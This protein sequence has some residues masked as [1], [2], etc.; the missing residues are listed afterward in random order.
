VTVQRATAPAHEGHDAGGVEDTFVG[1]GLYDVLPVHAWGLVVLVVAPAAAALAWRWSDRRPGGRVP[2]SW[3]AAS[4]ERRVAVSALVLSAA[5]HAALVPSHGWSAWSVL[6]AVDALALGGAAWLLISG[7]RGAALVASAVLLGSLLGLAVSAA[8]GQTPDQVAMLTKLVEIAGLVALWAPLAARRGPRLLGVAG[9]TLVALVVAVPVWG[10][11]LT[12]EAGQDGRGH[13]GHGAHGDD[14]SSDPAAAPVAP[15]PQERAAAE[16][17]YAR[18][19]A[20]LV[21]YADPAVAAADGYAVSG[22]RGR[23]FHAAHETYAKDGRVLD[24]ERPEYLIYAESDRGPLLLGAMFE[25]ESISDV[26]PRVGGPLTP[27]HRHEQVCFSLLPPTVAGMTSP[28]GLC[29]LGSLTVPWTAEMLHVWTVPGAPSR[30][31]D[32]PEA[33]LE[34]HVVGR[35]PVPRPPG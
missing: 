18:T 17:L 21:A 34:A 31:G 13:G 35:P 3:R 6:F 24:P 11:V 27:W 32:V 1:S 26:G 16:E 10:S 7:R 14:A 33:W 8:G 4:P 29:P 30:F 2:R 12:G 22:I 15:T 23:D 5:V 20:A 28:Y 25:M 9:V 19:R